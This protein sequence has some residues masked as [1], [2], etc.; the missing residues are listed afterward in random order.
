M[1]FFFHWA[2]NGRHNSDFLM[3]FNYTFFPLEFTCPNVSL[4]LLRWPNEIWIG[5][6]I[7]FFCY[8]FFKFSIVLAW[9]KHK[10]T[11]GWTDSGHNI[12]VK[13]F[14]FVGFYLRFHL[15]FSRFK[16]RKL[17]RL[18]FC[19]LWSAVLNVKRETACEIKTRN[20]HDK[21]M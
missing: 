2:K 5:V 12:A 17:R 9:E 3:W 21:L 10:Q 20:S 8:S 18:L 1:N 19:G 6:Y 13:L 16:A 7:V 4:K 11:N 15:S 14:V